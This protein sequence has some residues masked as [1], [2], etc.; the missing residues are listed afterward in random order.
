MI[1]YLIKNNIKL[2]MRSASN[3]LLFIA[4]PI[5]LIAVLSS[6]FSSLIESYE[7]KD[8][9]SVGY[10]SERDIQAFASGIEKEGISFLAYT[11]GDPEELIRRD[12]LS[13]FVVFGTDSYTIYQSRDHKYEGK[14]LEYAVGAFYDRMASGMEIQDAGLDLSVEHPEYMSP[15]DSTDYYGIIEIVYFGCCAIVCG[16]GIFTSERKNRIGKRYSVSG[17]SE[18]KLYLAK[19]VSMITV[20]AISSMIAT[21]LSVLLFHI[22]WGDPLVS[23]VIVFLSISAATALGLMFYSLIDNLAGT[24]IFVFAVVWFAGFFGGSFETYMF[25]SHA[26]NVKLISPLYH[27]NRALVEL[28]C[29]GKSDYV[30]SAILYSAAIIIVCSAVS[31]LT[32]MARKRGKA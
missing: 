19:F 13:G 10:I 11:E 20:V 7:K 26:R 31:V 2:M 18:P 24:I 9:I 32:G 23:A 30:A 22:H 12:D 21:L 17:V 16:A 27:V 4:A 8:E 5:V 1:R 6:A 15:I 14:I 3:V 29:N 28:S 25:S